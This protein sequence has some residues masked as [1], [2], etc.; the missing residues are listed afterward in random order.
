MFDDLLAANELYAAGFSQGDL[1]APADEH[2]ALVTCM[3]SR[4][5]PL[6]ALGL[7]LGE[8]KVIRNAGGRVTE[9]ALR[10]LALATS[11]LGV[12]RIAVMHHT[13]CAMVGDGRG[14]VEG[15]ARATGADTAGWDPLPMPDP[16]AALAADV[17][18]VRSS[19][20]VVP[21][22]VVA[23]WRYDVATGCITQVVAP[24]PAG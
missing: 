4:I 23:G 20:L 13:R 1:T 21:G 15:V 2:L 12:D 3:D 6:A 16:D 5:D 14:L 22:T 19:P 17:A 18:A 10:S 7:G 9:D 8:A 24:A 11:L